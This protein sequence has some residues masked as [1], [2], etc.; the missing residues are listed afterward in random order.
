MHTVHANI[1]QDDWS[2]SWTAKLHEPA[3]NGKKQNPHVDLTCSRL[4][5]N[6]LGTKDLLQKEAAKVFLL[7]VKTTKVSLA[8]LRLQA[9][10]VKEQD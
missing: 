9:R 4:P 7:R 5:K 2:I 3:F 1:I 10:L 6:T 8:I